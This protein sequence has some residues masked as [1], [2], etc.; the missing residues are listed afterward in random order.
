MASP[1]LREQRLH[2]AAVWKAKEGCEQSL[3]GWMGSA[4]QLQEGKEEAN[5]QNV[6]NR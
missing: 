2:P 1:C 5:K 4:V 6:S 3:K